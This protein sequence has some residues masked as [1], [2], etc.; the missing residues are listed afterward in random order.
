[1]ILYRFADVVSSGLSPIN[2]RRL[3]CRFYPKY[4]ALRKLWFSIN[5]VFFELFNF[6]NKKNISFLTEMLPEELRGYDILCLLHKYNSAE[7]IYIIGYLGDSKND[8]FFAK[9]DFSRQRK[10][11]TEYR[12]LEFLA[13]TDCDF[14]VPEIVSFTC[15]NI[16]SCLVTKVVPQD[17]EMFSKDNNDFK[18]NIVLMQD[19]LPPIL[20]GCTVTENDWYEIALGQVYNKDALSYLNLTSQSDLTYMPAHCDLGSENIF[21][22][23]NNQFFVIDWEDF[24][25]AAPSGVDIVGFEL[26]RHHSQIKGRRFSIKDRLDVVSNLKT[27]TQYSVSQIYVCLL[28]LSYL[29]NDLAERMLRE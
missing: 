1:M 28:F 3:L 18:P 9:I 22:N 21:I 20:P 12:V 13:K 14:K 29:G 19:F 6:I 5:Y 23:S 4:S 15:N 16:Y 8:M 25:L 11:T 17:F 2:R 10:I 27:E 7:K 24:R 26:G